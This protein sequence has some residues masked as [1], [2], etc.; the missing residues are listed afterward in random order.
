MG[1]CG[2]SRIADLGVEECRNIETWY[3]L[4]FLGDEIEERVADSQDEIMTF[5]NIWQVVREHQPGQ[6]EEIIIPG[7]VIEW[8]DVWWIARML[9]SSN[10]E[11]EESDV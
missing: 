5:E 6:D 3:L 4:H 11:K 9:V 8:I 7:S 2:M 10:K 1:W